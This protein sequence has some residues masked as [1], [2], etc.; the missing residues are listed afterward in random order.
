[1]EPADPQ[2]DVTV[3][4]TGG[5]P[6][7]AGGSQPVRLWFRYVDAAGVA[8]TPWVGEGARL[9]YDLAPADV[10]TVTLPLDPQY[11]VAGGRVDVRL[12]TEGTQPPDAAADPTMTIPIR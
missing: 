7:V 2:V 4:N 12:S 6:V 10:G 9:K 11:V 3:T 1:M 8:L 5:E